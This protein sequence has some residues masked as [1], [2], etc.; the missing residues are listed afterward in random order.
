MSFTRLERQ[1]QQLIEEF[2]KGIQAL[3]E[4]IACYLMAGKY[5][6][7]LMVVSQGMLQY[8]T[9][10]REKLTRIAGISELESSFAFGR[11]KFRTQLPAAEAHCA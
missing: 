6:Y 4:V 5:D 2:E 11:V 8:E 9:F 10:V 3:D 7:L 1:N